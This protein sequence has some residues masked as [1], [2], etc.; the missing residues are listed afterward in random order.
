MYEFLYIYFILSLTSAVISIKVV[1]RSFEKNIDKFLAF[2]VIVLFSPILLA[3]CAIEQI[4][5]KPIL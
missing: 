5:K 3:L 2:V 4:F 1:D